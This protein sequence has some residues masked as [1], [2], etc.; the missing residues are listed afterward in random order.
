MCYYITLILMLI[1]L[2]SVLLTNIISMLLALPSSVHVLL[3]YINTHAIDLPSVLLT[4]IIS[5]LL[6]LPSS[7]CTCV[8]TL[9]E[10]MALWGKP[11]KPSIQHQVYI[12]RQCVDS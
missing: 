9:G 8:I 10:C 7:A 2:P 6:A 5:M 1:D 11:N 12:F 4:N 3:H